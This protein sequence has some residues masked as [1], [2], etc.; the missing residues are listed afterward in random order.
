MEDFM[1]RE[2]IRQ[3]VEAYMGVGKLIHMRS[4]HNLES[5]KLYPGQPKFLAIIKENEG[6]TQKELAQIHNVKPATITG[7]LSK[8]EANHYVYR[9][10][11]ESDKRILRVYLTPEGRR[12]AEQSQKF[13]VNLTETMFRGFSKEELQAF[14][15]LTEKIT[16]NL[17]SDKHE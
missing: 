7:M 4:Y 16:K 5:L 1:E 17:Q 15:K 6:V 14:L 13:I 9:V 12:M 11:D 8:L 10:P 2:E 3:M